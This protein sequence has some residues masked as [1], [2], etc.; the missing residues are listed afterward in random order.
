[1]QLEYQYDDPIIWASA[2]AILAEASPAEEEKE[3]RPM[4]IV[5]T[6]ERTEVPLGTRP[7]RITIPLREPAKT[8]VAKLAAAKP[9]E[10]ANLAL[11]LQL[12]NVT[13][14]KPPGIY[15]EVYVNHP[16]GDDNPKFPSGHYVGNLGFFGKFPSEDRPNEHG[17]TAAGATNSIA[18]DIS[19]VVRAQ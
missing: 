5:A 10:A 3:A 15:Y 13:F 11:I 7:V 4:E 6:A 18:L 9:S 12:E 16:A 17:A 1:N 19:G 2:P 14:D 8:A